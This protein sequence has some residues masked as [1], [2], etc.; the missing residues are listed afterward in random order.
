VRAQ[1]EFSTHG[2]DVAPVWSL[3]EY[4]K[5]AESRKADTGL[6]TLN[7]TPEW[8]DHKW[9]MAIDLSACLGCGG[10]QIACQSENN[11]PVVGPEQVD[12]GR[13]MSWIRNDVYFDGPPENPRV[14]H[15]VMLC[16]QC[17]DAPCEPV[18]PVAATVHSADGL[19]EQVYN[20]CIGVRYCA[21]NCPYMVRRF[22]FFDYTSTITDPLDLAF[23]P[24]VT[25]RPRG[26]MEKCTFC[27]Q[28]IRN[29]VQIAKDEGRPARDGEIRP[30]CAVACPA[31]AIVFGD[32][33]DPDS[34]VSRL[35]RSNRGYKVLE[36]LGT[37][38]AVTYQVELRNVQ[39]D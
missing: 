32:L 19:N 29:G 1:T 23:N 36:D 2:R 22:N 16:Q 8:G 31:E 9:G 17:D 26:V 11:I 15:T 18:C 3:T 7:P 24:E 4:A 13:I 34:R 37:R 10:C 30:A 27:V 35:S 28:R 25:V 5:N 14:A 20:R 6:P 39:G 21:A 38:P 33:K 12:R